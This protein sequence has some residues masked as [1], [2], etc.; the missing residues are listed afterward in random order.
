VRA[1]LLVIA[2]AFLFIGGI[3]VAVGG[4]PLLETWRYRQAA[5]SDAAV[6]AATLRSATETTGTA[7]ELS[8]RAEIAGAVQQRTEAVPVHVWERVTPGAVVPVEH[9]PGRPESLRVVTGP[10]GDNARL[11]FFTALGVMMMLAALTLVVRSMRPQRPSLESS[12]PV[13][14][15]ATAAPDASYWPLARRSSDFWLGA[16]VLAVATPMMIATLLQAAEEWRFARHGVATDAMILTKEIKR[17]GRGQQSRRYEVTYRVMVPEGTFES[18]ARVSHDAWSRLKERE[19]AEVLYL[20]QR[21]AA[22]RLAGSR[23]WI[24]AAVLALF[25][26]VFFP[27]GATF[28]HRSIRHARLEW[29]LKQRGAAANGVVIEVQDRRLAINGVRQWRL[30]YEYGDF[31]G[32][33]HTGSH[34]L[35]EE[36]AVQW[37]IGDA[38]AVR[39][40]PGRPSDAIWLGRVHAS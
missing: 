37:K 32:G 34:D 11:V 22:N 9:L 12:Q 35:P 36:E 21:P 4:H 18:R 6:T 17:S 25:G 33:R 19:G 2:A 1:A 3:F 29:R 14:A 5:R 20:P 30:R 38:G 8:Y 16:I 10:S 31:Q 15:V 28:L 7:Y 40:D 13:S 23:E 39:Y 26:I 27:V 24:G